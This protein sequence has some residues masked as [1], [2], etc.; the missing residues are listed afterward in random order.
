MSDYISKHRP[1]WTELERLVSRARKGLGELSPEDLHRLDVLYRKTTIHLAQVAS[2]TGDDNLIRYLNDLTG[3][4]HNVIYLPSRKRAV[5]G[6]AMF[7]AEGFA[8]AVAR[9]WRCHAMSALL[10]I[11]GALIAYFAVQAD[12]AA[13]YALLP[14]GE[15]RQPGA[16]TERLEAVLRHGRD[17]GHGGKFLFASFLF[18]HNLKVGILS[19]ATGVL[20]AIPCI[21]LMLYNGMILGALT[22]VYHG[23]GIYGE[24]WA[25]ILPHG[26][27]ELS[28]I[29]LCGGIG[30]HLGLAVIRPG[31][32]TRGESLRLAGRESLFILGGVAVM[33]CFAAAIESYLRQSELSTPAR[34]LFAAV[35]ALVWIVYFTHGALRERRAS[36]AARV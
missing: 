25:W 11:A 13:A 35:T 7:L 15:F 14:P 17:I 22:A 10:L 3:A 23:N 18:S 27:T 2:R 21:F 1:E 33:L 31:L 5:R 36:R 19:M 26:V 9:T 29:V 16:S 6:V 30:L 4:A 34:L 12:P 28:A 24:Y 32:H 8:R 20:A